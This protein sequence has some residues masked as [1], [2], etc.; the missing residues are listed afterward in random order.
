[1]ERSYHVAGKARNVGMGIKAPTTSE[2][3]FDKK[4]PF[5]G[6][7]AIRGRI[8]RGVVVSAK[9]QRTIIVRR[10]YLH[11]VQKYKRYERRH[12]HIAVHLSPAFKVNPGDTVTIGECRPLSKTVRFNVIAHEPSTAVQ[13]KGFAKL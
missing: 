10:D 3:Y 11:F 13:K 12:K 6:D 7:V 9:M 5:R 2:E 8:L 4:C 1:M